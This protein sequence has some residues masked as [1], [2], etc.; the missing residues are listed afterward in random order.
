MHPLVKGALVAAALSLAGLAVARPRPTGPAPSAQAASAS[1]EVAPIALTELPCPERHLPEGRAC[2]PLPELGDLTGAPAGAQLERRSRGALFEVIP[3]RPDR[4]ADPAVFVYPIADE[5][6]FLRGFDDLPSEHS[7]VSLELS[8]VRGAPITSLSLEGQ[9]GAAEV[10]ATGRLVGTTVVTQHRVLGA[11]GP[12]LVLLVHGHL[13]A[14]APD[15][16]PGSKL[17]PG[18]LVGFVG[19]SGNPGVVSLYLEARLA[20]EEIELTGLPL[21]RL[22]DAAT[23]IPTDARNVLPTR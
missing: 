5:P 15:A 3:R 12:R 10:L 17:Q 13:D 9:D 20:R 23:S 19:D 21:E 7:P 22:L 18:D 4:P 16:K 11:A 6:L 1:S 8:A 2:V 14:I